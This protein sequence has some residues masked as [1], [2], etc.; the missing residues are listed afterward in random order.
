MPKAP[1]DTISRSL[2]H[3]SLGM[4]R[5]AS[6]LSSSTIIGQHRLC[7]SFASSHD[8]RYSQNVILFCFACCFNKMIRSESFLIRESPQIAT[9]LRNYSLDLHLQ[10]LFW[11]SSSFTLVL[12]L[13]PMSK[14]LNEL[15][16]M[17]LKL[18][19]AEWQLH[20]GFRK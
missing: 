3:L 1:Q 10:Y 7:L 8:V 4:P 18:Y 17:K 2:K 9:Y 14:L 19:H 16:I 6:H 13:Y 12:H 15:N 5:Q 11:S 20:I